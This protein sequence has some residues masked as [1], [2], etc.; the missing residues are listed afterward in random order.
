VKQ[1]AIKRIPDTLP[2]WAKFTVTEYI[3]ESNVRVT[4]PHQRSYKPGIEIRLQRGGPPNYLAIIAIK[5][6]Y[7]DRIG[8]LEKI[9]DNTRWR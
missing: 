7:F 2:D 8:H 6:L 4:V 9:L 1:E 5:C 3:R